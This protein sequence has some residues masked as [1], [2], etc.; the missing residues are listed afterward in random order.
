MRLQADYDLKMA[1]QDKRIMERVAR[2][3][4]VKDVA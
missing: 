4:P 2:I 3:V 1:V